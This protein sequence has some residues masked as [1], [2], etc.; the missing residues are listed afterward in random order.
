VR[1][2]EMVDTLREL[3]ATALDTNLSIISVSQNKDTELL[4]RVSRHYRFTD[5][6]NWHLWHELEI[7]PDWAGDNGYE[8]TLG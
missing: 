8:A 6:D 3:L 5:G 2:N 1:I 7:M 4:A